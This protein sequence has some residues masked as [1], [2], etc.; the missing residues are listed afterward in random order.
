MTI[1]PVTRDRFPVWKTMR[2]A[3]YTGV[4]PEFHVAE[5]EHVFTSRE[6][7]CFLAIA[8]E[9]DAIGMLE[10]SLRSIVDGCIGGPVGYIEGI[11]L[12]PQ[13]RGRGHGHAMLEWAA[14]WARTHGCHE[15]ATDAEID[16]ADAQAFYRN[17]GFEETWRTVQ[18]KKSL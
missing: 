4:D 2:Q 9:A 15:L 13:H 18:F 12:A 7:A 11:Y 16:N 14:R 5:M 10:L 1:V 3:L 17:L 8:N 6:M